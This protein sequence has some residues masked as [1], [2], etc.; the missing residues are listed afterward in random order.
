MQKFKNIIIKNLKY[1]ILLLFFPG[2]I[3]PGCRNPSEYPGYTR[4]DQGVYYRLNVIGDGTISPLPGDYITVDL[5]YAT[6]EDS[7]FFSARRK[8][9]LEKPLYKGSVE[10]CFAMMKAGD[11]ADFILDPDDFFSLT[12]GTTVPA[13]MKESDF[14]RISVR[15]IEVQ[16]EKSYMTEMQAFNSWAEDL[17][18]YEAFKLQEF[19][20]EKKLEADP[21]S[22]GL[23]YFILCEGTGKK[24][25][26]G[27]AVKIHYEGRFLD[28]R[29]FEST[30]E[31]GEAFRFVYGQEWQV[32]K[33]LDTAIGRMHE[34]EK[35]LVILPSELAYGSRGSS[36][37]LIPPYTTLVYELEIITVN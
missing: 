23:Y 9:Q 24:I 10:E 34:G 3:I 22:T 20:N 5:S 21:D 30:R 4:T 36:T 18:K 26:P 2:I 28:G 7:V 15:M 37:G 35:A 12:L 19:L 33:G 13:F 14:I 16:S 32:L 6:P 17:R 11:E 27:D 1:G 31:R 29:F 8:F 25:R